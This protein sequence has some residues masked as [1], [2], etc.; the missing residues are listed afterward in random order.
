MKTFKIETFGCQMNEHDSQNISN[1]LI[2]NGYKQ[3]LLQ[4]KSDILIINTCSVRQNAINK[5]YGH[6]GIYSHNKNQT[7]IVCGCAAEQLKEKIFA[8]APHVNILVGTKDYV[9]LPS[10]L[11]KYFSGKNHISKFSDLNKKSFT[12]ITSNQTN[13]SEYVNIS[14]GCNNKCSYCIVPFVRGPEIDVPFNQIVNECKKKVQNGAKEIVLLG[15]NVNTY[16]ISFGKKKYFSKLLS[17]V[18]K[19][20]GLKRLRF[21]SA[22][23][24]AL[25][26]DVIDICAEFENI[27][28]YLHLSL[29]SGSDKVLKDMKRSYR[30]S[31][32]EKI[33]DYARKKIPNIAISTDIIVGFPSE[34]ENDFK[35]T[36]KVVKK[37]QFDN[38]YEFIYSPRPYTPAYKMQQLPYSVC[39]KRYR[40]LQLTQEKISQKIYDKLL[41]KTVEVMVSNKKI[42]K[43]NLRIASRTNDFKLVYLNSN[44][45]LENTPFINAKITKATPYFLSGSAV[46]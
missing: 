40:I 16:G 17:E 33:I 15:Q 42:E 18:A 38:M 23:P 30:V 5:L 26:N 34:T 31:K 27:L 11:K 41:G 2:N 22:N 13:I 19:I 9:Y 20:N 8:R 25:T 21:E 46:L 24:S 36:L 1:I 3:V 14:T 28:P 4:E 37:I 39:Q 35:Q 6:L 32:F 43:K 7:I 10:L 12:N 45:N 44:D 29:Q